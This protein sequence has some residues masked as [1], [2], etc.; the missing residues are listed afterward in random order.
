[1]AAW[2]VDWIDRISVSKN[3][4]FNRDPLYSHTKTSREITKPDFSSLCSKNTKGSN[5]PLISAE[6]KDMNFPY[7]LFVC[8]YNNL[9]YQFHNWSLNKFRNC[10]GGKGITMVLVPCSRRGLL[11]YV[12]NSVFFWMNTECLSGGKW[13]LYSTALW[14]WPSQSDIPFF[15]SKLSQ[16]WPVLKFTKFAFTSTDS[17]KSL[18][19]TWDLTVLWDRSAF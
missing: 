9:H 12:Y 13:L 3:C 10:R 11:A 2:S 4:I 6:L 17:M 7:T 16:Y 14:P 5:T 19:K 18:R 15:P 8:F 1:M